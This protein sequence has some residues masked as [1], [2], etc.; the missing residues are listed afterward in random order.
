MGEEFHLGTLIYCRLSGP[1]WWQNPTRGCKHHV[2]GAQAPFSIPAVERA[3]QAEAGG[4]I[5][6][7][8]A[9][10]S[11]HFVDHFPQ[12]GQPAIGCGIIWLP[13]EIRTARHSP[14]AGFDWQHGVMR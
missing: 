3:R 2:R 6:S 4:F 10:M 9:V 14:E 1:V 7:C 5:E 11:A 8:L 13:M 12:V